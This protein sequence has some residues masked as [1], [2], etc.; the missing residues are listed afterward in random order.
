[1]REGSGFGLAVFFTLKAGA[2]QLWTA[3]ELRLNSEQVQQEENLGWW[4]IC[5]GTQRELVPM[6]WVREPRGT[7]Q[8]TGW[9]WGRGVAPC[10]SYPWLKFFPVKEDFLCHSIRTLTVLYI[11]DKRIFLF[12]LIT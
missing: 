3:M 2:V 8:N 4:H 1:M 12:K 11:L 5:P 6:G 10:T 7:G 9:G